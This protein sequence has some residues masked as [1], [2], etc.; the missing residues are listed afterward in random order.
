M[1]TPE[2]RTP[3]E[4][5]P[6]GGQGRLQGEGTRAGPQGRCQ[7]VEEPQGEGHRVGE[8]KKGAQSKRGS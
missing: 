2:E 5:T 8:R 7:E 4:H 1:S 3:E 6:E